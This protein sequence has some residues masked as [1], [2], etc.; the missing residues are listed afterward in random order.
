MAFGALQ[1][2]YSIMDSDMQEKIARLKLGDLAVIA[3][4]QEE[5]REFRGSGTFG[6]VYGGVRGSLLEV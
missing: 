6:A 1:L 3:W 2:A 4:L 5:D